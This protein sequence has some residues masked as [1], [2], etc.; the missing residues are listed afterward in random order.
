MGKR[1]RKR[2]QGP[3][4]KPA[5]TTYTDPEGN[6]LELRDELSEGTRKMLESPQGTAG[7]SQEDLEKRTNEIRFERLAMSWTVAGLPIEKQKEL[8][9]RYRMASSEEH[10]WISG[11]I[12]EHLRK[13]SA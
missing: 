8:V 9:D 5:S 4:E 7:A 10:A 3:R 12:A 13:K 2:E 1:S 6:T 11:T